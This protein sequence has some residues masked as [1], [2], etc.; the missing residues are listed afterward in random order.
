MAN[1]QLV[2]QV[3]LD[4]VCPIPGKDRIQ[5]GYIKGWSVIIP[6]KYKAGEVGIFYEI[7]SV[8]RD[9]VVEAHNLRSKRIKTM[10]MAGVLSQGL[11]L[12]E[13][14]L[15][16]PRG[17]YMDV[18]KWEPEVKEF[19]KVFTTD[20]NLYPFP[21]WIPKTDEERIQNCPQWA[22]HV[23]DKE[24]VCHEKIDGM[25]ITY[26][27]EYKEAPWWRFWNR[28]PEV[29]FG[30][31]SRNWGV[32][33]HPAQRYA[34]ETRLKQRLCSLAKINR[35]SIYVQGEFIGPGIQS[36]RYRKQTYE[37]YLFNSGHAGGRHSESDVDDVWQYLACRRVPRVSL[38]NYRGCKDVV[39]LLKFAEGKSQ[40]RRDLDREGV[41]V[42]TWDNN[43]IVSFK[44]ISNNYLLKNDG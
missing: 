25:S 39:S 9:E 15:T 12:S 18:K 37:W 28:T 14:D 22:P 35:R 40:I 16:L 11:F 34:E 38:A 42:R 32:R 1:R 13:S 24:W 19:K 2:R 4:S 31:C 29:V 10:K 44:V 36:N 5:K 3:K 41:V 23:N 6:K 27:V 33:N 43:P 8:L 30:V 17:I 21:S 26:Y 7:D 20:G